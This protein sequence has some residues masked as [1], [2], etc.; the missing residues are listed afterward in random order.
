M[1]SASAGGWIFIFPA[2]TRPCSTSR[3]RPT[4]VGAAQRRGVAWGEPPLAF[5]RKAP[6][7]PTL[8]AHEQ[9]RARRLRRRV[10]PA[11]TGWPWLVAGFA[12]FRKTPPMWLFLVFMYFFA[13]LVFGQIRYLGP[14]A[15]MV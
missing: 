13:E 9:E 1:E 8:A 6:A 3:G 7:G 12:L 10:V 15:F 14:A 4:A 5:W 2:S 11:R